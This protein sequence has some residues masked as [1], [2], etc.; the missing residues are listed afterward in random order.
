MMAR[1]ASD[2]D[3]A[4]VLGNLRPHC[5][6]ELM[7][8]RARDDAHGFTELAYEIGQMRPYALIRAALLDDAGGDPVAIFGAYC[9][10]AA[11]AAFQTFSTARWPLVAGPFVRWFNRLIAPQLRLAGIRVGECSVLVGDGVDLRW[12]ALMGLQPWG[13]P[14]PRGRNGELYQPMVW[15]R[16]PPQDTT[17]DEAR[18]RA[19]SAPIGASHV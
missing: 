7:A 16:D 4:F 19:G 5:R 8:T 9:T 13:A 15:L 12:F 14:L 6:R 17:V 11:V 3:I 2:Y 18:A 1:E 10:G